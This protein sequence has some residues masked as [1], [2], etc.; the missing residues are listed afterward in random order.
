VHNQKKDEVEL[1]RKLA[2]EYRARS[3]PGFAARY[4]A[5]FNQA[6]V[7]EFSKEA[8]LAL[9]Y[10]C[11]TATTAEYLSRN[12]VPCVGA[13]LSY[14]MLTEATRMGR[15]VG[16]LVCADGE[17][18]PF[19]DETFDLVVCR[20]VLHHLPQLSN[21][22]AEV[23]RVMKPGGL[24]AVSEPCSDALWLRPL[25]RVFVKPATGFGEYHHAL[26][27]R[28]IAVAIQAAGFDV[29]SQTHFGYV[30]FP[31]YGMP[32]KTKIMAYV[33]ACEFVCSALMALD[34]V[35]ARVPVIRT[36]AWH[37]MTWARRL[38]G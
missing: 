13:D 2:K 31:L 35:M 37:V 14:A 34:A 36:Q 23:F 21:G 15:C 18:L 4:D 27:S 9:D 3:M 22:L 1:H 38:E 19:K 7:R 20:G 12:G 11:G 16:R 5:H 29:V 17:R 24:L 28:A 26:P 32:D 30:A 6:L 8:R 10:G 33:P 25:R